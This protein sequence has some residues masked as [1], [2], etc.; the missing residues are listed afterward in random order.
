MIKV[1]IIYHSRSGNTHKLAATAAAAAEKA[2][3][4]PR[5]LK[6]PDSPPPLILDTAAYADLQAATADIRTVTHEDLLWADAIMIGTP[7]HFGLPAPQILDFIDH[8][9]PVAIPGKL[10]NKP[11]T[12]FATG[13]TPHAGAHATVLALHNALCHWG[14]L[15]VPNGTS[16]AIMGSEH[17]GAPYGTCSISRHQA[18][19][20]HED[21]LRAI[22]YQTLR[23]VEVTTAYNIGLQHTTSKITYLTVHDL[24]RMFPHISLENFTQASAR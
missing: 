16:V 1:A 9:G 24:H 20:V 8:S 11:V 12:V 10:A 6:V 4:E 2:G 13:S 17:N 15:I 7:V 22:E 18:A 23:L 19:N 14:S 3:A 21:N 5:L